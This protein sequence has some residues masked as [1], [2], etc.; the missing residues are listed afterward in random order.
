M[1]KLRHFALFLFQS[2]NLQ[3]VKE[4]STT[5]RYS[6]FPRDLDKIQHI[7][8]VKLILQAA[9]CSYYFN[10]LNFSKGMYQD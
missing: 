8:G 7:E 2:M 9:D 5:M 10:K 6:V 1:Y 4:H 3:A